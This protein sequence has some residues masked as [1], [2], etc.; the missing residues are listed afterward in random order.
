MRDLARQHFGGRMAERV[1]VFHQ[2]FREL[3]EI[4]TH[5]KAHNQ[6]EAPSDAE[7]P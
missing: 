5:M 4:L 6:A 7:G 3:D 2:V 1:R